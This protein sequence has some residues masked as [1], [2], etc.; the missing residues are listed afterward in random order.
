MS[1]FY[2][3]IASLAG[4]E[5]VLEEL[6]VA[7]TVPITGVTGSPAAGGGVHHLGPEGEHPL[8]AVPS[9]HPAHLPDLLERRRPV[10]AMVWAKVRARVGASVRPR[11][12][13]KVGARVGAKVG[14]RVRSRV[15]ARVK[16][17]VRAR[18]GAM[19]DTTTSSLEIGWLC[20]REPVLVTVGTLNRIVAFIFFHTFSS[21]TLVRHTTFA[22]LKPFAHHLSTTSL[23]PTAPHPSPPPHC[24]APSER[25]GRQ[26]AA[27]EG[28]ERP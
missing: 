26:G 18:V 7:E 22:S 21:Q 6:L 15:G 14:A 5:A 27:V 20:T 1:P 23:P 24:L 16:A 11:V 19:G 28:Q 2:S 10:G 25:P 13:A 4:V 12:G 9:P 3:T 17:R 8:V